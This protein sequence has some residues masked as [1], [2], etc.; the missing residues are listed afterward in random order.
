MSNITPPTPGHS[1]IS[2][3]AMNVVGQFLDPKSIVQASSVCKLWNEA[4]MPYSQENEEAL[5]LGFRPQLITALRQR[6]LSLIRLP[7]L[8]L[9]NKIYLPKITSPLMR[10]IDKHRRPGLA[11]RLREK[12]FMD[13]DGSVQ[14]FSSEIIFIRRYSDPKYVSDWVASTFEDLMEGPL[15]YPGVSGR[16]PEIG[17]KQLD[18]FYDKMHG[19]IDPSRGWRTRPLFLNSHPARDTAWA[20]GILMGTDPFLELDGQP[21]QTKPNYSSTIR[22]RRLNKQ[23]R[24]PPN[25]LQ[26]QQCNHFTAAAV[27]SLLMIFIAGFIFNQQQTA[28]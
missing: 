16:E 28:P 2:G 15:E 19:C 10:F 9:E 11:M 25:R 17:S 21:E 5:S 6:N 20:E 24:N 23:V 12:I 18:V 22:P 27:L 14:N 4:L 3:D 1:P 13:Q 26:L 7:K 8:H